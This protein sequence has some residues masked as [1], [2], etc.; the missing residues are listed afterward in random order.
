MGNHMDMTSRSKNNCL[1]WPCKNQEEY[2]T[3][4]PPWVSFLLTQ[5]CFSLPLGFPIALLHG[6]WCKKMST[7]VDKCK[8]KKWTIFCGDPNKQQIW[9]EKKKEIGEHKIRKIFWWAAH[10]FALSWFNFLHCEI[11]TCLVTVGLLWCQEHAFF[12]K[13]GLRGNFPPSFYFFPLCFVPNLRL[14]SAKSNE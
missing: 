2:I 6:T 8:S 7:V 14:T 4:F 1:A 3:Q 9:K 5:G 11:G 12:V 13:K 10:W